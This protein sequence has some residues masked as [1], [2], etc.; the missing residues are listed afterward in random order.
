MDIAR[1]GPVLV[2]LFEGQQ[3]FRKKIRA[4]KAM[5]GFPANVSIGVYFVQ[6]HV[7]LLDSL[8]VLMLAGRIKEIG[9]TRTHRRYARPV[10]QR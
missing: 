10:H 7:S 3:A 8:G 1:P 9:R 5:N 4:W 6:N 2:L